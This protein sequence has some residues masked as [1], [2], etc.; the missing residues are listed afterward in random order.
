MSVNLRQTTQ[1]C[2]P[3]DGALKIQSIVCALHPGILL[4]FA[5]PYLTSPSQLYNLSRRMGGFRGMNLE[6]CGRATSCRFQGTASGTRRKSANH[7]TAAAFHFL[8]VPTQVE[9]IVKECSDI[10][11]VKGNHDS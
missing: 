4:V 11:S 9:W 1:R 10:T 2:I 3:E 7:P 5:S 6:E 8:I